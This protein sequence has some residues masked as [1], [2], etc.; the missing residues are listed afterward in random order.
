MSSIRIDISEE[1]D[2][3]IAI[4]QVRR[5][6]TRGQVRSEDVYRLTTVVAEFARNI[7]K[8]AHLG[9]IEISLTEHLGMLEGSIL[10]KDEG[11][12][13]K[14]I[15]S[16]LSDGFST[17]GSLGMGLPG[18]RRMMDTFTIEAASQYG[19]TIRA[20]RRLGRI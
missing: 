9:F 10:A 20:T 8:Y 12:G 18:C 3:S 6:L 16:A 11:P 14:D 5:F 4:L 13:I 7:V 15:N 17:G 19:T 2:V 1:A